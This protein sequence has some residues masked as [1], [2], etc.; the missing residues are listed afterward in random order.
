MENA[1]TH[2][3][4]TLKGPDAKLKASTGSGMMV[5]WNILMPAGFPAT[6]RPNIGYLPAAGL[7][8]GPANSRVSRYCVGGLRPQ[9]ADPVVARHRLAVAYNPQEGSR[10][11]AVSYHEL[12]SI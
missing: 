5:H 2:C 10:P 7:G 11:V 9:P 4:R 3:R 1:I 8:K 12:P 6:E